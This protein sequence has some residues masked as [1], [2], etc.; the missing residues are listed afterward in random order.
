MVVFAPLTIPL[1]RRMQTAAV[2][3]FMAFIWVAF[4]LTIV[5]VIVWPIGLLYLGWI[6]WDFSSASQ[7][8]RSSSC[9]K[10]TKR[11][12]RPFFRAFAD[13]FPAQLHPTQPLDATQKYFFAVHPH[14]ILGINAWVTVLSEG[15]DFSKVMGDIDFR[16]V[17]LRGN[18]LL[19][20]WRDFLLNHGLVDCSALSIMNG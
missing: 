14:G 13:Y 8:G 12:T 19:P 20:F 18:F 15:R 4:G 7:G 5:S 2:A 1:S 6:V 16:A 10:M 9:V 11:L 17:T 3:F